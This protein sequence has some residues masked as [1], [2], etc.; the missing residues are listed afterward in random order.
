[1]RWRKRLVAGTLAAAAV[2]CLA[3]AA[4]VRDTRPHLVRCADAPATSAT[5]SV[6]PN[7]RVS[8][9]RPDV[10]H[11]GCTIVADPAHPSRLF[12][13]SMHWHGRNDSG[14]V[15]YFSHD[16]GATWELGIERLGNDAISRLGDEALAFSG[17]RGLYL[18]HM[19]GT[20]SADRGSASTEFLYSGDGGRSWEQRAVLAGLVDRPQ[21]AVDC[22]AGPFRGRVY[23]NA[24][25]NR[26]LFYA[27][28][29][30]AR[31]LE[32][33]A[34]PDPRLVTP[35]PGNPVVLPDGAVIVAYRKSGVNALEPP[36]IPVCRSTD[37]GRTFAAATTVPTEW[38]HPRARS[39]NGLWTTY[40][41]LAAD[42]G[43]AIFSGRLYCVWVDGPS[44]DARYVLFCASSD[45]GDTWTAPV[46]LSEQPLGSDP[47][48]DWQAEIPAIAVNRDGVVAVS[49]YD[50]R[51]LAKAA[52]RADGTVVR[53]GYNLRLRASTDG[54]R[55]WLPSVQLNE[56]TG[57]GDLL[58][59]RFWSGLAADANGDFHPAWVSDATGT[60]QVWSTTVQV[61]QSPH[62]LR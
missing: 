62:A 3:Y 48:A 12:A 6:G 26:P 50:R 46:V 61:T 22:T 18:A 59:V 30:G 42:P 52:R 38:R 34:L 15:G 19:R 29:D 28:A 14:I 23:C 51:G 25:D 40:P 56:A 57:K 44:S 58:D 10:H 13:A 35:Y 4:F 11:D 47:A 9:A 2:A 27:S 37:G 31:T 5:M 8:A 1:M 45:R 43:S 32:P 24:N 20:A 53:A 21:L 16:G 60:R 17:D 55:I 41:L 33:A 49:W 7:V 36:T 54:G 39:N